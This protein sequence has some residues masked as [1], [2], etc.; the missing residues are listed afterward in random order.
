L[1]TDDHL[2]RRAGS[3]TDAT[4]PAAS[5]SA[6]ELLR[7]GAIYGLAGVLRAGDVTVAAARG[8]LRGAKEGATSASNPSSQ[9]GTQKN[10]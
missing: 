9:S 10:V 6:R 5:P 4:A 3:V 8:A 2:T 1:G 7:R